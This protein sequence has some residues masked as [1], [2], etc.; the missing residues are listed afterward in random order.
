MELNEVPVDRKL[1]TEMTW[2]VVGGPEGKI[3]NESPLTQE[4]ALK[5]ARQLHESD[6]MRPLTIRS[7]RAILQE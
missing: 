2:N 4:E 6:T 7:N 5:M 3:L 1:T